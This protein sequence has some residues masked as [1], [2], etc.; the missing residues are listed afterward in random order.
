MRQHHTLTFC[1]IGTHLLNGI[2]KRF[3]AMI[4]QWART[5]LLHAVAKWPDVI[6]EDTWTYAL[7]HA[8]NFH[9]ASI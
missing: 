1:A 4:T 2:A 7:Q 3:I 5:V 9:N 6:K 8:I